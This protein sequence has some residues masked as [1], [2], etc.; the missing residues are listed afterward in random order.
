MDQPGNVRSPTGPC[1]P[2]SIKLR[3][4]IITSSVFMD[5]LPVSG[6]PADSNSCSHLI[7]GDLLGSSTSQLSSTQLPES[8]RLDGPVP[9]MDLTPTVRPH[10][11]R[12]QKEVPTT[13]R[14]AGWQPATPCGLADL[15]SYTA[16]CMPLVPNTKNDVRSGSPYSSWLF[17]SDSSS[18]ESLEKHLAARGCT[19]KSSVAVDPHT[20]RRDRR[21][22]ALSIPSPTSIAQ[23]ITPEQAATSTEVSAMGSPASART[24]TA[25]AYVAAQAPVALQP[26][27]Q[28]LYWRPRPHE[29][30][31]RVSLPKLSMPDPATSSPPVTPRL[32]AISP[33]S[34]L[35]PENTDQAHGNSPFVTAG[36]SSYSAK[37]VLDTSLG[38]GSN[39]HELSVT[40]SSST[41]QPVQ[42]MVCAPASTIGRP[43]SLQ[44]TH[45]LR[46]PSPSFVPRS[47]PPMGCHTADRMPSLPPWMT[48]SVPQ[49]NIER[50]TIPHGQSPPKSPQSCRGSVASHYMTC[51]SAVGSDLDSSYSVLSRTSDMNNSFMRGPVTRL[52]RGSQQSSRGHSRN[53]L[54]AG[55]SFMQQTSP[56]QGQGQSISR[57][58]SN[59]VFHDEVADSGG[60]AVPKH[61]Q[62]S[63]C[64]REAS[65]FWNGVWSWLLLQLMLHIHIGTL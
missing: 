52:N 34:P 29:R 31:S 57:A 37:E 53:L 50:V 40:E 42:G 14:H 1:G 35:T 27:R 20:P 44:N 12:A 10:S 60:E 64:K 16:G 39:V 62:M 7:S 56:Q 54:S 51:A 5:T 11:L 59:P 18:C 65:D 30:N 41:G 24:A 9:T 3:T 2:P 63:L 47:F 55:S 32:A 22:Q 46:Y 8:G 36:A 6:P 23:P 17:E 21:P 4:G 19:P 61:T 43:S 58:W 13:P 48:S 15:E 45:Q 38:R 26:P 49:L 33:R 28:L 25:S